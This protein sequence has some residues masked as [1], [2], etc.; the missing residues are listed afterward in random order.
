MYS[1]T[2]TGEKARRVICEGLRAFRN[3][4]SISPSNVLAFLTTEPNIGSLGFFVSYLASPT[5]AL[6]DDSALLLGQLAYSLTKGWQAGN[7]EEKIRA[8]GMISFELY[9][10]WSQ[11]QLMNDAA[12]GESGMTGNMKELMDSISLAVQ[13]EDCTSL[14]LHSPKLEILTR[15]WNRRQFRT[16]GHLLTSRPF[17]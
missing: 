14:T 11:G 7:I 9:K 8:E 2:K 10:F 6:R 16:S 12:G 13:S 5:K 1:S 4:L 3:L 15:L 17:R